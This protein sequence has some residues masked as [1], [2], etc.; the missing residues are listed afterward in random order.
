MD[1]ATLTQP[2]AAKDDLAVQP[3]PRADALIAEPLSTK[4]IG[5]TAAKA[6][7]LQ[8]AMIVP[9]TIVLI[10][11]ARPVVLPVFLA[12]V[13]AMTLMS[14]PILVSIKVV[15][16]RVPATAPICELLSR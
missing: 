4:L 3:V 15:C 2:I 16:D 12:C 10:Y 14:V 5:P 13:A 1:A 6:T 7:Q 8:I 11:F 9:G